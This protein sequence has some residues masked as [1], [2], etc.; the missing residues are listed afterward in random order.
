MTASDCQTDEKGDQNLKEQ[1]EK[2]KI[3]KETIILLK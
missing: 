3:F 2:N 1:T